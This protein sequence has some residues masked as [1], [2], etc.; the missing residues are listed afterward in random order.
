[1]AETY[2]YEPD[3]AVHPGETLH[4]YIEYSPMGYLEF[5]EK[6]GISLEELNNILAGKASITKDFAERLANITD[7][8]Y[9]FW[10][11]LQKRYDE[12]Q[13]KQQAKQNNED[14]TYSRMCRRC[15]ALSP[16]APATIGEKGN[17]AV[18]HLFSKL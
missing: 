8:S 6:L 9:Q 1:M 5:A 2:P 11:N 16:D 3:F 15:R 10:I 13:A 14:I 4:E 7:V 17:K 12:F 18:F